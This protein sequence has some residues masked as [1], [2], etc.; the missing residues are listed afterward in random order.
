M[1]LFRDKSIAIRLLILVLIICHS[2][3][4]DNAAYGQ[5][6]LSANTNRSAER[7]INNENT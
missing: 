6:I 3:S 4:T 7:I 5:N 2:I 1:I